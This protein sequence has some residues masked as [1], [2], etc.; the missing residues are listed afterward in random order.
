[1]PRDVIKVSALAGG[2]GRRERFFYCRQCNKLFLGSQDKHDE[3]HY[4]L[5]HPT[6][7]PLKLTYKLIKAARPKEGGSVLVPFV[8][9]GSEM[10]A[11]RD[12]GMQTIGFDINDDYVNMANLLIEEGYPK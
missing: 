1:L 12:L 2:A 7:K 11:A 6:Q 10:F 4:T 3:S 8:G 5:S 9:T